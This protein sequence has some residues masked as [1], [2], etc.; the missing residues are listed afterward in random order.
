MNEKIFID[1][2]YFPK[3]EIRTNLSPYYDYYLC[4]SQTF[5]LLKTEGFCDVGCANGPLLYYVKSNVPHIDVMGLEYFN[6]QKEA[7]DSL[8][9]DSINI[10]DLRDEWMDEKK[11]DLVNCTETGEHIDSA[12]CDAFVKNLKKVCNKYLIISWSDTGG[13]NDKEHDEHEQH[14]NP[15][16]SSQVDELLTRNGFVKNQELTDKFV[17]ESMSKSDFNFWWRKSLGVWE[18]L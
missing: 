1:E 3:H 12:Y 9:K 15:L 11:Y 4:L 5:N 6:W 10:H 7:A 13:A 16:S 2:R 8:I 18:I 14:L 17:Q